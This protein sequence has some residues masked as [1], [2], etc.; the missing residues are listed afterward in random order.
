[1]KNQE[2]PK[3]P[4]EDHLKNVDP[5]IENLFYSLNDKILNF[6][7]VLLNVTK[8]GSY[9]GYKYLGHKRFPL[10]VE[11]HVQKRNKKIA[12][13]LRPIVFENQKL[14]TNQ[15]L[16]T[17][18]VPDSHGWSLNSKVYI[19]DKNDIDYAMKLIRQSYQ[20]IL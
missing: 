7:K 19:D 14:D 18:K 16:K 11:V 3:R 15:K 8:T 6:D 9:I 12:L 10:F 4:I 20:D 1:M 17:T 13:H 5:D 2:L